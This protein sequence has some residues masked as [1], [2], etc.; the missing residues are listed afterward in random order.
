MRTP[1]K[2]LLTFFILSICINL[3]VSGLIISSHSY[4]YVHTDRSEYIA[5]ESVSFKAYI[6]SPDR[7]VAI[8]DTLHL[9]IIDQEGIEVTNSLFPLSNSL[10]TGKLA[11]PLGISEGTY[12][13]IAST[14]LTGIQSPVDMFSKMIEVRKS[15]ESGLFTSVLLTD[16]LYRPGNE[17]TAKVRFT[18]VNNRPVPAT[19]TYQLTGSKGELLSGKGKTTD[20]GVSTLMLKLPE[21]NEQE[22]IR[23]LITPSYKG[24]RTSS[25]IVIPTGNN[26]RIKNIRTF[27][28]NGLEHLKI[29]ISTG[30]QSYGHDDKVKL[31]I[32][33][34]DE[35]G[36]PVMAN[37]SVSASNIV[38]LESW[39]END[40][41]LKRTDF[42]ITAGE[43]ELLTE[44]DSDTRSFYNIRTR[45][46]FAAALQ[47]LTQ[48]PGHPYIVQEKNNLKKLR[49]N[50]DLTSS[51]TGYSS[52][53]NIFDIIMQIKPYH[54]ENGKISFGISSMNSAFNPDGA[55]IIID[56][57]KKG[58]DSEILN[59]IAVQDIAR[60][61][62][63]TN[64]MD[65][66]KYSAM[67]NVGIIE[68]FMK[69]SSE[70]TRH[71]VPGDVSRTN[72]LFWGPDIITDK[73]GRT[74]LEFSNNE[75]SENV[76]IV[77]NGVAANG[78]V[79]R[80]VLRYSVK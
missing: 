48:I 26:R 11:L 13:L 5:G 71:E 21:F 39:S 40:D 60:I 45:K 79:G 24:G 15:I 58:T 80:G 66:Q 30:S 25:A 50:A 22:T 29:S 77:I 70:F 9:S 63:S 7:S 62:V 17:I 14:R 41:I 61:N 76:M 23:L 78:A 6:L 55:L 33:V 16:T 28:K 18:G 64:Q 75:Y 52:D 19:F 10:I 74:S 36:L 46:Y 35:K 54:I 73:S 72:T 42:N 56:G 27:S 53:R 3:R 59:S 1:N 20:D 8:N 49:K 68:I 57:I 12:M 69:K 4:I 38:N 44:E 67:N 2:I 65:V 43:K 31:E 47:E 34:T 32:S 51:K 37:L